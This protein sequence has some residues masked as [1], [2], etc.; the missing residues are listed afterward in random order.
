MLFNSTS[1][2]S[3]RYYKMTKE[4]AAEVNVNA[5]FLGFLLF[6]FTQGMFILFSSWL[7]IELGVPGYFLMFI[8][9]FVFFRLMN[10]YLGNIW[11]IQHNVRAYGIFSI[12]TLTFDLLSSML[13]VVIFQFGYMG[14]LIGS[15]FS[16][17]F[18]SL[19]A[20]YFLRRDGQFIGKISKS[21][22]AEIVRFGTPL[23]PHAI[24]GVSLAIANR[25]LLANFMDSGAVATFVVAYQIASV[26]LLVGT[27]INQ[28]WS[29]YLFQLLAD[30]AGK[31]KIKIRR[32]M[33]T[34]LTLLLVVVGIL[35]LLKNPLFKLLAGD[36][37]DESKKYFPYLICGFFFQSAYFIF[38]NFDFYEERA[39]SIGLTTLAVALINITLNIFL[40]PIYG[41]QGAAYASLTGMLV[42]FLVVA[43]RV[44]MF[45]DSFK[46]VWF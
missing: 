35:L 31:N 19:F 7:K 11:Q 36:N 37:F 14:R 45:N 41:V 3:A 29:V 43:V 42:Y 40:I 5:I 34:L 16:F 38:V 28:A 4:Q 24:G 10:T 15:H 33:L 8:P 1:F 17:L 27:S 39:T 18:F 32:L 9:A 25:Y 26:M 44:A 46:K 21:M 30:G 13:L 2:L 22:L 23:I 6:L 20:L 12:G